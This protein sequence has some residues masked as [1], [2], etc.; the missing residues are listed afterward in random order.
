[1]KLRTQLVVVFLL[2]AILPLAGIVL[3]SYSSSQKAF[4]Q[5]VEKETRALASQMDTRMAGIHDD[6][7]R[8]LERVGVLPLDTLVA[9]SDSTAPSPHAAAALAAELGESAE[10]L[11]RIEWTT[12]KPFAEFDVS[13]GKL[14]P[15]AATPKVHPVKPVRPEIASVPSA[16]VPPPPPPSPRTFVIEIPKIKIGSDGKPV[17]IGSESR[18]ITAP[19]TMD[20]ERIQADVTTAFE[21]ARLVMEGAATQVELRRLQR[22]AQAQREAARREMSTV[23]VHEGSSYGVLTARVNEDA[24]VRR[25]LA[26]AAPESEDVAFA[27]DADGT[28][29]TASEEER[30][31]LSGLDVSAIRSGE[32]S[33]NENWVVATSK[34]E[35]TG[36]VFGVAR[37]VR[38]SLRQMRTNA[39]N[40]FGW[41]LG[42][43][44]LALFGIVPIANHLTRDIGR[45]M[46]GV[47]RLGRGDLESPVDVRSSNEI[48]R[49][50]AAFNRMAL[51]LK[52]HQERLLDEERS[53]KEREIEQRLLEVEYERKSRELED[54][55]DFQL[56]LLPADPPTHPDLDISVLV[57]TATEVGGDYYDYHPGPDGSLTLAIGDAT[58]HGARAGTM[59]TVVKSLFAGRIDATGLAEFL[60]EGNRTIR[61]MNLERMAMALTVAR[62][63]GR[64]VELASAG[65]PPALVYRAASGAIE[66]LQC[67]APPLGSL[68]CE[69][70]SIGADLS[71]GDVVLMMTDGFP[72]LESASGEPLGYVATTSLFRDV[73]TEP[74]EDILRA[75]AEEAGRWTEGQPPSDDMTF[76][77]IRVRAT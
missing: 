47:D 52:S 38:E 37:P 59:V 28:V 72:E 9:A 14:E 26:G 63:D 71:P 58:G 40:N 54:A 24:I 64:R 68:A 39:M 15:V 16:P 4:R 57:R 69:Y 30:Q 7:G 77:A 11:D 6:L 60:D 50:A 35:A 12:D 75:F 3:F 13:A 74:T 10:F 20:V 29:L 36:M 55:R 23:V 22:E 70:R 17:V 48:G 31:R 67:E 56:S 1:M 5:A 21:E 19:R 66:E 32:A 49:L 33:D 42:L 8:R 27:I 51:D 65:M 73:A 25:V 53:R 18:T 34:D 2:L 41:G 43:V 76:V 44:A 46:D 45:V 62:V 61:Q